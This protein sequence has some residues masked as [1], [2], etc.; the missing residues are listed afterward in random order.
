MKIPLP[1]LTRLK[2]KFATP[3]SNIRPRDHS[4]AIDPNL[5]FTESAILQYFSGLN[6]EIWSCRETQNPNVGV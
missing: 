2:N 1:F 6:D 4:V 3:L 5:V